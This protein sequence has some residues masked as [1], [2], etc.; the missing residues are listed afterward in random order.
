MNDRYLD[1]FGCLLLG[2]VI[3]L[4]ATAAIGGP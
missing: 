3:V 2:L 1:P 4:L